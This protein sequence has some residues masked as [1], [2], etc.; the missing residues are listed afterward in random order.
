M[1]QKADGKYHWILIAGRRLVKDGQQQAMTYCEKT[2][3]VQPGDQVPYVREGRCEF[4]DG[5]ANII[6]TAA[7]EAIQYSVKRETRVDVLHRALEFTSSV[8]LKKAI[9]RRIRKLEK[10]A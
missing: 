6:H 2:V 3:I 9:E 1:W 5:V 4:C 10:V 8:T 7:Y